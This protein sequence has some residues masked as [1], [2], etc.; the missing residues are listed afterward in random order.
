MIV[1]SSGVKK[2]EREFLSGGNEGLVKGGDLLTGTWGSQK[3][4]ISMC[5]DA[6]S[7]AKAQV[8]AEV[9]R[10]GWEQTPR[11]NSQSHP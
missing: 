9:Q 7:D 10:P 3:C 2:T 6:P 5:T 8:G 1:M 4:P 11:C